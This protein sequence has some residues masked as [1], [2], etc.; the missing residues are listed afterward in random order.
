M[1]SLPTVRDF[2]DKTFITFEPD[3]D[4]YKAINILLDK[5]IMGAAVVNKNGKLVGVLSEKDCLRT[6]VH[7]AYSELPSGTVKDFMTTPIFTIAPNL[8][9]FT[10]ADIFLKQ[11]FRRLLVVE[12]DELVGQITRR[13][14]LR[15]IRKIHEKG[16]F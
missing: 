15:V 13:D 11:A 7:D 8:D 14:L 3:M 16:K 9:I 5:R 12:N 4:V 1:A 10:V 6:L 2:M